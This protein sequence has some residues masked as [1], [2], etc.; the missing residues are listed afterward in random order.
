[1]IWYSFF[2]LS[3]VRCILFVSVSRKNLELEA[4]MGSWKETYLIRHGKVSLVLINKRNLHKNP[5]VI[6]SFWLVAEESQ[7]LREWSHELTLWTKYITPCERAWNSVNYFWRCVLFCRHPI[8]HL[9]MCDFL[10]KGMLQSERAVHKAHWTFWVLPPWYAWNRF[11]IKV[12]E[13]N[14]R[15]WFQ[16]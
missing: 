10:L 11:M 13:C 2:A 12:V 5:R 7:S 8:V 15:L 16:L 1:M 3:H 4:D 6:G 14:F 9:E